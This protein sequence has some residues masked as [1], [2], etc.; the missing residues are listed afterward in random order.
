MEKDKL[1]DKDQDEV[2]SKVLR[3]GNR[4]YFF[5]VKKTRNEDLYIV[6][7]ESKKKFKDGGRYYFEKHKVFLYKEDFQ[8]FKVLMEQVLDFAEE[9]NAHLERLNHHQ[10]HEGEDPFIQQNDTD[11]DNSFINVEFEDLD[12]EKED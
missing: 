1:K 10:N 3:A 9:N 7:T 8:D 12:N 2:F 11:F 4:S 6:I 5:D